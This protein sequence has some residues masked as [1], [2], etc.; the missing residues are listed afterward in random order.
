[1]TSRLRAAL[2]LLLAAGLLAA[3][4]AADSLY[5]DDAYQP[6]AADIRAHRPGDLLTVLVL[7]ESRGSATATADTDRSTDLHARAQGEITG[8]G[9]GEASGTAEIQHD[10]SGEGA[11][12]R[13][14][15]LVARVSV[16]V[17]E[18][19]PNGDLAVSGAQRIIFNQEVQSI[20]V[21]GNV[22]PYDIA[23]DNTV[24][25]N[26]LSNATIE[27]TGDGL[28]ARAESKSWLS[29]LLDWIF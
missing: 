8:V 13:S 29:R 17:T 16:T 27:Y 11:I 19:L 4:A 3:E 18:V 22:R 23:R 12:A 15:R 26:R 24:P 2:A 21:Q 10:F 28:L 14:G 6:L 20:V 25:S 5:S 9:G 7:E 1:M